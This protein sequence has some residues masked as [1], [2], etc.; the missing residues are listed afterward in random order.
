MSEVRVVRHNE[1]QPLTAQTPGMTRY[2]GV[3]ASTVGS[4]N[5]WMGYVTT[6]PG[7]RSGAHHHGD[8][9]TERTTEED[10]GAP[11][12]EHLQI[13]ED[14]TPPALSKLDKRPE[15]RCKRQTGKEQ[16]RASNDRVLLPAPGTEPHSPAHSR[17]QGWISFICPATSA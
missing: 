11:G 17:S 8:G 4:K 7:A 6:E 15:E 1:L 16:P 3:A 10:P 9:E 12:R 13:P 2:P 5:L 14:L